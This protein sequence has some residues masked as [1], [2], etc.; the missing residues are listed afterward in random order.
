MVAGPGLG[1][2]GWAG[3][4]AGLGGW[5]RRLA[6]VWAALLVLGWGGWWLV[7][8]LCWAAVWRQH[9]S[10]VDGGG[11]EAPRGEERSYRMLLTFAL[12]R[13]AV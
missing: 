3:V 1:L 4:G 11:R 9:K 5:W 13:A 10:V 6:V 8:A 12:L 2:G 7:L